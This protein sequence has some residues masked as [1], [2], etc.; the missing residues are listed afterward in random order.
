MRVRMTRIKGLAESHAAQNVLSLRT[1]AVSNEKNLRRLFAAM[2][3]P[4]ITVATW[5]CERALSRTT[6]AALVV[7]LQCVQSG[8]KLFLLPFWAFSSLASNYLCRESMILQPRKALQRMK[9]F[10]NLFLLFFVSWRTGEKSLK[11]TAVLSALLLSLSF[12]SRSDKQTKTF[13]S[14]HLREINSWII[15]IRFLFVS[16]FHLISS[17]SFRYYLSHNTALVKLLKKLGSRPIPQ[18]LKSELST[19]T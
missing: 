15:I 6:R 16:F 14:L 8:W 4:S 12:R 17:P 2:K 13:S 9:F 10:I 19:S 3:V 18:W 1:V 11:L 7:A 5:I